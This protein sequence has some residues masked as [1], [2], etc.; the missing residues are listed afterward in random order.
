MD[1]QTK[2]EINECLFGIK[3]RD[4][5]SIVR[6]YELIAHSIRFIALKY[7]KNEQDAEDLEQDFWADIY[8]IADGFSYFKNGFGYLCKVMTRMALNRYK[9]I[10][11][12]KQRAVEAV[13]YSRIL[14]F[15]ENAAAQNLDD[16][17]A[18]QK[19][20]D[21]LTPTERLVMQLIIFEDKTIMQIA[22]ELN[23][24]KSQVGRLKKK[25]EDKLKKELTEYET[26]KS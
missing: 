4:R 10:H 5:D 23:I 19:A 13:D 26:G 18:V 17:I 14:A 15:D 12:E 21:K 24:S 1:K 25:A 20:L 3:K 16:R 11:G 22:K 7:L 9:K 8:D 6:L 2:A